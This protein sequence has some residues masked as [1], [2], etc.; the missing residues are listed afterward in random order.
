MIPSMKSMGQ[1][2]PFGTQMDGKVTPPEM[3]GK[4]DFGTPSSSIVDGFP[5]KAGESFPGKISE[6]A[7]VSPPSSGPGGSS[8]G[9][10]GTGRTLPADTQQQLETM[11]FDTSP[12]GGGTATVETPT[13]GTDAAEGGTEES[14]ENEGGSG[15][16]GGGADVDK[17][18]REVYKVLRD[19]LRIE[20]ER[21]TRH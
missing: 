21:R 17:M 7:P 11:G 13:T 15:Q 4:G 14:S 20:Q 1:E 6:T 19:R 18:A 8:G 10:G 3:G 16:A 12:F 5:A 9:S 2:D